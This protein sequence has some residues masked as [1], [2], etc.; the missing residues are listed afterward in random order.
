MGV[1]Q[2]PPGSA[3]AAAAACLAEVL[4]APV[5]DA[6]PSRPNNPAH[7]GMDTINDPHGTV[8]RSP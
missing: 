8:F 3:K 6:L 7:A 1:C 4:A 5:I 2:S